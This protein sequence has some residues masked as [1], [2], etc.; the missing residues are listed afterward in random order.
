LLV[1]SSIYIK[2]SKNLEKFNLL[3]DIRETTRRFN[4][5]WGT[6]ILDK[7][8]QK[9]STFHKPVRRSNAAIDIERM[10]ATKAAYPFDGEI[11]KNTAHAIEL[12]DG[13]RKL[14]TVQYTDT[15]EFLQAGAMELGP[16]SPEAHRLMALAGQVELQYKR[17]V[18]ANHHRNLSKLPIATRNTIRTTT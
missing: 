12:S 15:I 14:A 7:R 8:V 17:Y 11:P 16:Q 10:E 9:L 4:N 5:L 2:G 18:I 1:D 3:M 6:K 13:G